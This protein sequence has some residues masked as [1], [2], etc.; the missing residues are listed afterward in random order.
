MLT[1]L[2]LATAAA[3]YG[4]D[5]PFPIGEPRK[6]FVYN[7]D[8][9]RD[10]FLFRGKPELDEPPGIFPYLPEAPRPR[11]ETSPPPEIEPDRLIEEIKEALGEGDCRNAK[12]LV[13]W[14]SRRVGEDGLPDLA[15]RLESL[16][17]TV[18]LLIERKRAEEEFENLPL[19][20]D[21][22]LW[23]PDEPV[24][25]INGRT[26]HQGDLLDN[27]LQIDRIEKTGVVFVYRNFLKVH[28]GLDWG[29][30]LRKP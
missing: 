25:V 2:V 6:R 18:N 10:P 21:A 26:R 30:G 13:E 24:A 7:R 15:Q 16:R 14:G 11:P 27:Q 28:K 12:R 3:A 20:I 22:I 19:K 1:T 5:V 29:L 4:P 17:R 8:G 9:R 23:N